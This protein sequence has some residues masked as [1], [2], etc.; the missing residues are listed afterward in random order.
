MPLG[1]SVDKIPLTR[2]TQGVVQWQV[3]VLQRMNKVWQLLPFCASKQLP[4]K[5]GMHL[6]APS[7]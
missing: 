1:L 3:V 6:P 7:L 2:G 4:L 5:A